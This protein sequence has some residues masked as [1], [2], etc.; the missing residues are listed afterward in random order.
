MDE[1]QYLRD[2]VSDPARSAAPVTPDD[3]QDMPVVAKALFIGTGGDIC[4][5]CVDDG[6]DVLF[7]NLSGGSIL[8]VRAQAVRATGTTASDIVALI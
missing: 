4:L 1:F 8:P 7:R 5:R 6:A 2:S 3:G